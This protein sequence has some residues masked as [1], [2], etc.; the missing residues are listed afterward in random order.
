MKTQNAKTQNAWTVDGGKMIE[1]WTGLR[2]SIH[3][4][5]NDGTG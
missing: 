4:P 1:G 5:I 2:H 3:E